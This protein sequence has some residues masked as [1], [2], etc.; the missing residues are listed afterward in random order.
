MTT[1]LD[2]F[3][4]GFH[5]FMEEMPIEGSWPQPLCATS[6]AEGRHASEYQLL[7]LLLLCS[8]SAPWLPTVGIW[9]APGKIGCWMRRV[10]LGLIQLQALLMFV[11]R[12]RGKLPQK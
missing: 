3:T 1:H 11:W 12:G 7:L 4:R 5:E 2:S 6:T 10:P 9:V 8:H